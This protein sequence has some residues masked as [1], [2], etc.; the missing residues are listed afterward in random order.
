MN[1]TH[2]LTGTRTSVL[3]SLSMTHHMSARISAPLLPMIEVTR[4]R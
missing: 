2:R 1:A 3:E 4:A